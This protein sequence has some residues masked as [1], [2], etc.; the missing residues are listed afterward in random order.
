MAIH[1][2]PLIAAIV[3]AGSLALGIYLLRW[4]IPGLLRGELRYRFTRYHGISNPIH[5]WC[6]AVWAFCAGVLF[7]L[8]GLAMAYLSVMKGPIMP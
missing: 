8:A 6:V 3:A 5:F 4:V 2:T 1:Q 7:S